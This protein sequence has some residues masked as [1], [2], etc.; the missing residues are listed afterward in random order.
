MARIDTGDVVVLSTGGQY[1]VAYTEDGQVRLC[2]WPEK[3]VREEH[4]SLVKKASPNERLSLLHYMADLKDPR[5]E[6][7]RRELSKPT[8]VAE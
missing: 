3:Q 7:A 5:G 8:E 6:Y 1:H 4:C 2:T